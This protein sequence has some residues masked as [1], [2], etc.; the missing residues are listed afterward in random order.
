MARARKRRARPTKKKSAFRRT[1]KR[2]AFRSKRRSR[3]RV[4]T[5]SKVLATR[6]FRDVTESGY[7]AVRIPANGN[8]NVDAL[9][10]QFVLS[11][12]QG[13]GGLF[14]DF[15]RPAGQ[16]NVLLIPIY[17]STFVDTGLKIGGLEQLFQEYFLKSVT[18]I[19]EPGNNLLA[20]GSYVLAT[21]TT[22]GKFEFDSTFMDTS[23]LSGDFDDDSML[24][25]S[26]QAAGAGN[27]AHTRRKSNRKSSTLPMNRTWRKVLQPK[28]ETVQI[29]TPVDVPGTVL[30]PNL[31][32][33]RPK[34]AWIPLDPTIDT[35]VEHRGF[36]MTVRPP[37]DQ[38]NNVYPPAQTTIG[39]MRF[40][41]DVLYRRV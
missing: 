29:K 28:T 11:A 1:K 36:S 38:F 26:W 24:I 41:F 30:A 21:P 6:T 35:V 4:A 19:W 37:P 12:A 23:K 25:S 8:D 5:P 15:T 3:R 27:Q 33:G 7:Y 20:P 32:Q 31:F 39:Q 40:I 9:K 13:N 16:V 22:I 2:A 14:I 18:V 34:R 10:I 17:N